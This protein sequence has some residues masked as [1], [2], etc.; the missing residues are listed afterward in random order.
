MKVL[1]TGS[2]GFIGSHLIAQLKERDIPFIEFQGDVTRPKDVL[3]NYHKGITDIIHLAALTFVPESWKSPEAYFD[4]NTIGTWN[5]LKFNRFY[6]RFIYIS[7][8]HIYGQQNEF[9]IKEN[10]S[11]NPLDPYSTSKLSAETLVRRYCEIKDCPYIILRP[12]NCYGV[13]QKAHFFI[14]RI[15]ENAILRRRITVYGKTSRDW[16][17]VTDTVN[18]IIRVL[19]SEKKNT[20]YNITSEEEWKIYD[21]A[22]FVSQLTGIGVKAIELKESDR[23]LDIIRLHGSSEKI[24]RELNW[25]PTISL[26]VGLRRVYMSKLKEFRLLRVGARG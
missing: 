11:P 9:P 20:V 23:P 1:V 18:A 26:D 15:L 25:K 12:F 4:V 2:K 8:A 19:E 6:S 7:T 16:T 13:G 17:Y 22:I 10:A 5:L 14:P 24:R 21:L 3:R